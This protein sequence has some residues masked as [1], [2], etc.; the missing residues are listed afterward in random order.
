MNGI[1]VS[2]HQ[3]VINW[4]KVKAAG[5]D[6]A[7]LRAGY[8]KGTVDAQFN[9]NYLACKRLGIPVGVYWY[10][11]ASNAQQALE[12]AKGLEA[13]LTGKQIDLPIFYDLEESCTVKNAVEIADT[14]C[15]YMEN[16][17]YYVGIYASKAYFNAHLPR[18]T[19]R[20]CGWVAQWANACTFSQPYVCWQKSDKGRV[21]GING[22]VDLDEMEESMLNQ[23]ESF[24]HANGFNGYNMPVVADTKER[25]HVQLYVN[26]VCVYD[27]LT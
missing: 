1:D 24:I 3:G 14:F 12:E 9:T 22:F 5:I 2:N 20:W 23:I 13:I 18:A 10:S 8:G 16:K 21:D 7:I 27:K 17:R 19:S 6:F 25:T 26:G 4:D 15:S 11:Y